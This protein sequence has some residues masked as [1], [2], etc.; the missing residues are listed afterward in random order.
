MIAMTSSQ[1]AEI[2]SGTLH[3]DVSE[4]SVLSVV[5]DSREV[6]A[7]SMFVAIPGERADGHDFASAARAAGAVVVLAQRELAVPHILVTDTVAALGLLAK[8]VRAQLVD[9]TV[10]AVTGSSGKTS[11]KDLLAQLLERQGPTVAAHG[12]F[13]TEVGVPL[14]ILRASI[15]TRFLVLEMGMRGLGHIA[16]LCQIATPAIAVL[17]NIGSAHLGMLGSRAEVAQAKGEIIAALPATGSAIMNADDELVRT[18]A[19]RTQAQVVTFG[20]SPDADVRGD[21]VTL[22]E[23]ARATF[24]LSNG[25]ST[26]SVRLRVHGGH[27]VSNALAV[28]AV[29][30]QIGIP[31]QDVA[32]GLTNADIQSRWRMEVTQTP[33]AVT[34]I[35][36]AYNANPESMD[37]ALSTLTAMASGRR[38]WAVLGGMLELGSQSPAQ[39]AALGARVAQLQISRLVCVGEE[40][41]VLRQAADAE[42]DWQG[43]STWVPDADSAIVLL[44]E[45]LAVTDIVLIKASRGIGLERVATALGDWEPQ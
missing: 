44:R 36:D 5:V 35:N 7:G 39:H 37:A 25:R 41:Q 22:D 14:T 12:S 2:V 20:V 38:T 16:Y 21:H 33:G 27:F 4:Q 13:N 31:I 11:T 34:V 43:T 26:A 23:Q 17:L 42:V 10:I 15:S 9:C 6:I 28:A 3:G 45:Q 19:S 8:H 30:L 24:E 40:T 1:I 29:G 32:E 18:Q